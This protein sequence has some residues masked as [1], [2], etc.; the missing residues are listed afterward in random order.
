MLLLVDC[1]AQD[2][3]FSQFYGAPLYLNPALAGANIHAR[4]N[5]NYRN[6]WARL[7]GSFVSYSAS[8]DLN[9]RKYKSGVGL[10]MKSDKAGSVG[11]KSN[12]VGALYSYNMQLGNDLYMRAGLQFSYVN[13]SVNFSDFVFG[14]QLD[15][16]TGYTGGASGEDLSGSPQISYADIS[17]GVL[18]HDKDFW[19]GLSAHH[20]NEPTHSFAAGD[21]ANLPTRISLHGGIKLSQPD[22]LVSTRSTNN[23]I[24]VTPA[25][26]YKFQG[27][28]DQLD[29]GCYVN[30]NVAVAGLW[31]RGLPIKKNGYSIPNNEALIFLMGVHLKNFTFGY[32]YDLTISTLGSAS[33]G[34]HEISLSYEFD[35]IRQRGGDKDYVPCPRF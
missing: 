16:N 21:S 12:E 1:Q 28:F 29:L 23:K 9:I 17:S 33:G 25:F 34:S 15:P 31:Y 20:M 8:T 24:S 11:L 4:G 30:Y 26:Q 13:R 7:P 2:S 6:Q 5:M 14:N 18:I 3:Q 22:N 32:S 10:I 19:L 35:W 27:T